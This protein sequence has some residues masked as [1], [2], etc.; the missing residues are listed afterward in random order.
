VT[1]YPASVRLATPS[2][3]P[4]LLYHVRSNIADNLDSIGFGQKTPID[5]AKLK[6]RILLGCNRIGGVIGVIESDDN[7][8]IASTAIFASQPWWTD[9]WVLTQ[10]WVYVDIDERKGTHHGDDLLQFA[11]WFREDRS[12]AA[13]YNIPLEMGVMTGN[14]V[15]AKIRWWR[16]HTDGMI[17][18]LFRVGG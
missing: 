8:I 12:V 7:E 17:G 13:G 15:Q 1:E 11:K 6:E 4:A 5:E 10:F 18:A 14:R 3:A 2:D 16:R 9:T